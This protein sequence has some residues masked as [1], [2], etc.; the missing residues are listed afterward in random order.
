M[1]CSAV[2]PS[3]LEYEEEWQEGVGV[4]R[5]LLG[6]DERQAEVDVYSEA[7]YLGWGGGKMG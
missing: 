3:N 1:K 7:N 2:H 4:L 6:G 5:Q